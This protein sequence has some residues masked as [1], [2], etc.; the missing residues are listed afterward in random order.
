MKKRL[1]VAA[2][3]AALSFGAVVPAAATIA[4]HAESGTNSSSS[5][6][7]DKIA[8]KFSLNKAEVQKV[9]DEE[10][11]TREAEREQAYKDKLATA[12]KDGKLTQAQADKAQAKHNEIKAEMEARHDEMK[13]K[14]D[15]DR[16]ASMEARRTELKKWAA[17]NGIDESYLRPDGGRGGHHGPRD[18]A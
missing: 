5:S 10:R 11:A 14:T 12:V 17:D 8:S 2:T 9:F 4:T 16:K 1:M 18:G 13:D 15:A 7:V 3:A 6:I